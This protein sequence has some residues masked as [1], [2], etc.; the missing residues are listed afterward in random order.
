MWASVTSRRRFRYPRSSLARIVRCRYFSSLSPG[1][2]SNREGGATGLVELERAE[3]HPVIGDRE[4]RHPERG[5]ALEQRGDPGGAVEQRVLGM[6]V[7]VDEALG[8]RFGHGQVWVLLRV[9]APVHGSGAT[10]AGKV[11]IDGCLGREPSLS[12]PS[13]N[14]KPVILHRF[15]TAG[16]ARHL[17]P[18]ASPTRASTPTSSARRSSSSSTR[19]GCP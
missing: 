8:S 4:R 3:H 16:T 19:T 5:R 14:H 9:I 1:A 10:A 6:G 11:W 7:E 18:P 17:R 13:W 15:P 12:S 2:R